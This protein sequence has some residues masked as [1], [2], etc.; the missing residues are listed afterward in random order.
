MILIITHLLQ[1]L[2]GYEEPRMPLVR[3]RIK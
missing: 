3:R 1:W 2:I